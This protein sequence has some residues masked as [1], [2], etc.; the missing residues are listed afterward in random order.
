[1]KRVQ[2]GRAEMQPQ[3][4]ADRGFIFNDEHLACRGRHASLPDAMHEAD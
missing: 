1:V 4:I 3:Q 2:P